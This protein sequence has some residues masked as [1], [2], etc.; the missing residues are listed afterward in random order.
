M[1]H[2]ILYYKSREGEAEDGGHMHQG[3]VRAGFTEAALFVCMDQCLLTP[4]FQQLF[5]IDTPYTLVRPFTFPHLLAQCRRQLA[6]TYLPELV[7]P[8]L[9]RIHLE[10]C[11]HRGEDRRPGT[12]G[13]YQQ[14]NFV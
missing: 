8:D 9:L 12:G 11:T 7:H 10:C 2:D 6:A 4:V 5:T 14:V 3:A 13:G 1:L